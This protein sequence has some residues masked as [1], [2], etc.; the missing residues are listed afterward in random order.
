MLFAGA[1]VAL[2]GYE[3]AAAPKRIGVAIDASFKMRNVWSAVPKILEG[4]AIKH[5]GAEFMVVTHPGKSGAWNHRP[6]LG[7]VRPFAPRRLDELIAMPVWDEAEAVYLV[8][9]A[10]TDNLEV[11]SEW[12]IVRGEGWLKPGT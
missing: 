3:E 2:G 1:H 11:P 12:K 7:G 4:I 9:N 5:R 8:T 6:K 10:P